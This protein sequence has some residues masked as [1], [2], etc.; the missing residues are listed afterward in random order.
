MQQQSVPGAR[1]RPF[2][3]AARLDIDVEVVF[4]WPAPKF[5]AWAASLREYPS[6]EVRATAQSGAF[7][8]SVQM[9]PESLQ[10]RGAVLPEEVVTA[11]QTPAYQRALAADRKRDERVVT[12]GFGDE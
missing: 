8:A 9:T 3:V 5:R 2:W 12:I 1:I 11:L 4:A 10:A 6:E 7:L